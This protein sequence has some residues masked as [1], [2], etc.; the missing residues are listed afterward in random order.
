MT[1]VNSRTHCGA[2]TITST[3]KQS[4]ARYRE[5]TIRRAVRST[6]T[7]AQTLQLIALLQLVVPWAHGLTQDKL[8]PN[9]QGSAVVGDEVG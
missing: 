8:T 9:M 2:V 1:A 3:L 4:G 6:H 7:L 5:C